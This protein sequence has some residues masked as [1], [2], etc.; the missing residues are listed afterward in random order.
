[1]AVDILLWLKGLLA[2]SLT[3]TMDQGSKS[4]EGLKNASQDSLKR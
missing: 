3:L 1:M 2:L 4:N